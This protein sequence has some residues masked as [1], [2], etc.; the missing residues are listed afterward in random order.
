MQNQVPL[1]TGQAVIH[2][3]E[4]NF[5]LSILTITNTDENG[6]PYKK[7][8]PIRTSGAYC[9]GTHQN[10]EIEETL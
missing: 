1:R 6:N 3:K 4:V 2:I 10:G 5:S 8:S 9:T 7:R